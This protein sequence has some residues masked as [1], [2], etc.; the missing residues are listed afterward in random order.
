MFVR[1][2][3][4]LLRPITGTVAILTGLIIWNDFFL[5]LV[6]LSGTTN[7]TLP[8]VV[9][10]FVG[11]YAAQWNVVF[12]MVV[13]SIVPILAFYLFAQRTHPWLHRRHQ[14]LMASVTFAGV[15][16]TYP[17]GTRAVNE[18]TLEIEDGEFLILVGRSGCGKTTALRMVAGLEEITAASSGSGTAGKRS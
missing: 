11:N 12:A 14:D 2:V 1:V 8:V 18:L 13:V 17:D 3:F 9:Y 6:F 16:K 5:P 15:E 4:P 10:S 7:V